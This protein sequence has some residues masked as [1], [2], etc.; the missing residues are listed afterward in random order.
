[1]INHTT[2]SNP[3]LGIETV[4]GKYFKNQKD[5]SARQKKNIGYF[6]YTKPVKNSHPTAAFLRPFS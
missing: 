4:L 2:P 5:T 1:M 6:Q 3:L